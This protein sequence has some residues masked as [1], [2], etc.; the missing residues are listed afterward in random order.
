MFL[1]KYKEYEDKGYWFIPYGN[2]MINNLGTMQTHRWTPA[3]HTQT[4]LIDTLN[5]YFAVLCSSDKNFISK[6]V[7]IG[8]R[9]GNPADSVY[10]TK[11]ELENW[12]Y[13]VY[14][15]KLPVFINICLTID[16]HNNSREY[17]PWLVDKKYTDKEIYKILNITEEEQE[18]IDKII[19]NFDKDSKF[20]KRL[21]N[22][23]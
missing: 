7:R 19:K 15:N 5:S 23:E 12:H 1:K 20:G 10:G 3:F 11:E 14:N 6:K 22:V 2:Y 4:N 9:S 17:V 21:F 13:F 16:E 18:L 8:S